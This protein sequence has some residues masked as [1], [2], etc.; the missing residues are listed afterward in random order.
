M[1][2]PSVRPPLRFVSDED[3]AAVQRALHSASIDAGPVNGIY[4]PRTA[5]AV[6]RFQVA[7]KLARTGIVDSKTWELLGKTTP[8]GKPLLARRFRGD[9]RPVAPDPDVELL[10]KALAAAGYPPEE[11]NGIFGPSTVRAV[12]S[13][14]Q[15]QG[16]PADGV[17][18]PQTWAALAPSDDAPAE[19]ARRR[20][21]PGF[22][23]DRTTGAD[24]LGVQQ[25]VDFLATTL[26]AGDLQTPLAIGL[27]GDWGSG[28]SFFMRKLQEQIA[29]LADRSARAREDAK[30]SYFCSHVRQVTFN[31]WLYAD[32]EIWPS[33]AAQIFRS[34]AGDGDGTPQSRLQARDLAAYQEQRATE[35]RRTAETRAAAAREEQERDV[36]IAALAAEIAE[37]RRALDDRGAELGGESTRLVAAVADI[38]KRIVAIVRSWR[39][40]RPLQAVLLLAPLVV[41][42]V[43]WRWTWLA[44]VVLVATP[45]VAVVGRAV[46]YVE[47]GMKLNAEL[48]VL[49]DRKRK[50]EAERVE[51]ARRSAEAA[52]E[53]DAAKAVPLLPEFAAA[54]ASRWAGREK[55]GVVTEIRLAFEELSRLISK[56]IE[57]RESG[58]DESS[59]NLPIDR[60]IVYI[61]DLDRCSHDVVVSVLESIKVLLDLPNFVVVVGVA[62]RWLYRSIELHFSELMRSDGEAGDDDAWMSTPQNYLEKIFQYSLVLRPLGPDGFERLITSLLPADEDIEV[63]PG[64]GDEPDPATVGEPA[65]EPVSVAV[66]E[67]PIDLTPDSLKISR[68]ELAFMR[69]LA[70]LFETPRAAKRFANVYRL[71][72]VSIGGER[73]V[74]RESYEPVLV[75]L[76]VALSFPALAGDLMRVIENDRRRAWH[77]FLNDFD[78]SGDPPAS[79]ALGELTLAKARA[80]QR[81]V[82]ALRRIDTAEVE[83]RIMEEFSEWIPYVAEFSFHPWQ[84]LL[85]ARTRG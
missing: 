57:A 9:L 59:T 1:T 69:S 83:D 66:D 43:V 67:E 62:S 68:A 56:T 10:Q 17:V 31:A 8:D 39:Q 55:L 79:R 35:L 34:V 4:G 73:L 64:D 18:G 5:A 2:P 21:L 70:P 37:K 15:A 24:L 81:L 12:Q 29:T 65:P 53:L 75:L 44:G 74:D 52:V 25:R 38:G 60:V 40:L 11:I 48:D 84:D 78:P 20:F 50:L 28:K 63:T 58:D 26:A 32:S 47:G 49:E 14:Q 51:S 77:D 3:V 42:V 54:Q 72:R 30:P 23:A 82:D 45:V 16:L 41:A 71:L 19:R 27:F 13:F 33:L 85:P 22:D 6:E 80:W 76:A 61:D 36:Q 46:A 7:R